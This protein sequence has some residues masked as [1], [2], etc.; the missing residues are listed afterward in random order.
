MTFSEPF[1]PRLKSEAPSPG[2][3]FNCVIRAVNAV[4]G[5][6]RRAVHHCVQEAGSLCS[7]RDDQLVQRFPAV[8][9]A[10]NAGRRV[11][12]G[13][14]ATP[15]FVAVIRRDTLLFRWRLVAG[16]SRTCLQR[17]RSSECD[18]R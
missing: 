14:G 5:C 1:M 15:V 4:N 17:Y 13:A 3:L 10:E 9:S 6:R 2:R 18:A 8:A 12:S 7:S 11:G 16:R